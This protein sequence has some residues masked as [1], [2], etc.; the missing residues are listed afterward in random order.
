VGYVWRLRGGLQ[1]G[2]HGGQLVCEDGDAR[3]IEGGCGARDAALRKL[4]VHAPRLLVRCWLTPAAPLL[5][6]NPQH[7]LALL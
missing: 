4:R 6:L 1:R 3:R 2:E 5:C 7:R